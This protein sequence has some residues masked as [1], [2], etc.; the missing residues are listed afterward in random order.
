MDVFLKDFQD[1][2]SSSADTP[3]DLL[4][5]GVKKTIE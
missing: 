1:F 3:F 2:S 5:E 4:P